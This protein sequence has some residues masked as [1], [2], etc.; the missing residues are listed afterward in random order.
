[1]ANAEPRTAE[2][3]DSAEFD[4]LLVGMGYVGVTLTAAMLE[5]GYRV[6]GYE[7]KSESARLLA[8]RTSGGGEARRVSSG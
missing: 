6:L 2:T 3:I 5:S 7:S 1:M 4:V 8:L